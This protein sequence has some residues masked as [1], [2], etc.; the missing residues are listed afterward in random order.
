MR[1]WLRRVVATATASIRRGPVTDRERL[2]ETWHAMNGDTTLRL[3]FPLD[4]S[5]VVADVGGYQGQ[6]ASDIY[7]RFRCRI[8]VY[9]PAAECADRIRERFEHNPDIV[10][11]T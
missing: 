10:V 8:H 3:D 2:V 5:S 7:A 9:E 6:W 11:H 1:R 4:T